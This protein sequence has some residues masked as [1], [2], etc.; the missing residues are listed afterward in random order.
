MKKEGRKKQATKQSNLQHVA[1]PKAVIF[2]KKNELLVCADTT[3]YVHFGVTTLY[4]HVPASSM[5]AL[6]IYV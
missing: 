5:Y 4:I 6:Y 3:L 2:P 1:T